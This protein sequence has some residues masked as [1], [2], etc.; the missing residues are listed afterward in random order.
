MLRL[1]CSHRVVL[2]W[3][4][5]MFSAGRW[6][7]CRTCHLG[8]QCRDYFNKPEDRLLIIAEPVQVIAILGQ[9][10]A[11][12]FGAIFSALFGTWRFTFYLLSFMWGSGGHSIAGDTCLKAARMEKLS[13]E[14][15]PGTKILWSKDLG[16]YWGNQVL[17][18]LLVADE[19]MCFFCSFQYLQFQ[20]PLR[21][22][23]ELWLDTCPYLHSLI[24]LG[25]R[26]YFGSSISA[27]VVNLQSSS[28]S[29]RTHIHG[30][31]GN[32]WHHLHG[33]VTLC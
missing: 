19:W 23:G 24:V 2:C 28:S 13:K 7:I 27:M 10:I 30:Y 29:S 14:L 16:K 9:S 15:V 26:G 31:G 12:V 21:R 33:F 18:Y 25:I 17:Y 1:C 5:L 6:G 3:A 20:H 8:R 11:P 32:R 22:R 4:F